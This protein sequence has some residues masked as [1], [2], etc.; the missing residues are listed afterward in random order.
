MLVVEMCI[1]VMHWGLLYILQGIW[2]YTF[3]AKEDKI[4]F[5]KTLE[6]II[7]KFTWDLV[8]IDYWLNFVLRTRV[9]HP[10]VGIKSKNQTSK[11]KIKL[12]TFFYKPIEKYQTEYK[13]IIRP[14]SK[15][16]NIKL[17]SPKHSSKIFTSLLEIKS[18][19]T[20]D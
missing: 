10:L 18:S 17:D 9:Y 20:F 14:L 5:S 7:Y 12:Q 15:P 8:I 4:R 2:P 3:K 11:D 19:L 13:S 1:Q 16:K 6:E